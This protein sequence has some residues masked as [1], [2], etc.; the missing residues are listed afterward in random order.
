MLLFFS[1]ITDELEQVQQMDVARDDEEDL[2]ADIQELVKA[3]EHLP[4]YEDMDIDFAEEF[5]LD[6]EKCDS[7]MQVVNNNSNK[8]LVT[9]N[10]KN[11]IPVSAH[12]IGK[13]R[14]TTRFPIF[15]PSF[16]AGYFSRP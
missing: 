6:L 16:H 4:P 14:Q 9:R 2:Y 7:N 12:G 8:K 5:K 10:Q 3:A 1:F 13:K 15:R 11:L